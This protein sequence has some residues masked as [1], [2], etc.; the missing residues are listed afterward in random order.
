MPKLLDDTDTNEEEVL[1]EQEHPQEEAQEELQEEVDEQTEEQEE[2][3]VSPPEGDAE[4][5][6]TEESEEEKRPPSRREQLRINQLLD[7]YGHP[8]DRKTDREQQGI[9]YRDMIDADDEVI[10]KLERASKEFGTEQFNSG[11]QEANKVKWETRLEIDSPRVAEKYPQLDKDSDDFNPGVANSINQ[12][13]L[14]A[15]GYDKTTGNV[16]EP[17]MRYADYVDAFFELVDE[18]ASRK[19]ETARKN[20][21]RQAS[22]T[23]IRPSGTTARTTLDLNKAPAAMTDKELDA[24]MQKMGLMPTQKR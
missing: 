16:R 4:E 6:E 1:Q 5:G 3:E 20:V 17:N 9:N 24:A 10:Q 22:R 2:E 13:Y 21:T 7:R 12:L 8:D 15:V 14:S 18:A 11:L 19:T 23:G